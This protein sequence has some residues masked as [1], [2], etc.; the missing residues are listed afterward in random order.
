MEINEKTT[1]YHKK[2]IMKQDNKKLIINHPKLLVSPILTTNQN[3]IK[4][5]NF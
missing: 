2:N 5:G 1:I 4:L 3:G